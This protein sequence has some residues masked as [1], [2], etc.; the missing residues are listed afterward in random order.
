MSPSSVAD[1]AGAPA[2]RLLGPGVD[3]CTPQHTPQ[4]YKPWTRK[5]IIF[6]DV[7]NS[8]HHCIYIHIESTSYTFTL[9]Q[10]P[11]TLPVNS[12]QHCHG[13]SFFYT[14]AHTHFHK[15]TSRTML[16]SQQYMLGPCLHCRI[17]SGFISSF[18][19]R[20]FQCFRIYFGICSQ[21]NHL[22]LVDIS[23]GLFWSLRLVLEPY[24]CPLVSLLQGLGDRWCTIHSIIAHYL[25]GLCPHLCILPCGAV[26][27][28]KREC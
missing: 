6:H 25:S 21:A 3:F 20:E 18:Q 10:L 12:A 4:G 15:L 8:R 22:Y 7:F 5:S 14:F 2:V 23:T 27:I 28:A 26:V 9:I 1:L 19:D 16:T 11:V 13:L 24:A 17:H